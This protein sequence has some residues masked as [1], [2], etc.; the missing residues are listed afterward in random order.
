VKATG[1]PRPRGGDANRIGYYYYTGC[2]VWISTITR[3]IIERYYEWKRI[4]QES[5][6]SEITDDDDSDVR[7]DELGKTGDYD[8]D[9][10]TSNNT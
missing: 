9:E 10:E 6:A 4:K 5:D 3:E 7:D 8:F 2:R 1:H